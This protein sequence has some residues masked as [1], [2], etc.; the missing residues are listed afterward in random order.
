M[1][2]KIGRHL[3]PKPH[4]KVIVSREEGE[5]HYLNGYRHNFPT[6]RTTSHPG[7]VTLVEGQPGDLDLEFAAR[8]TARYSQGRDADQVIVNI[9]RANEDSGRELSVTPLPASEIPREWHV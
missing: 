8:I 7:P 6:I 5:N 9:Q 4:Y 3:R 1:L 2:L